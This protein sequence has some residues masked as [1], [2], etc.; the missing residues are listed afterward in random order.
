MRVELVI[1]GLLDAAA[2]VTALV[3]SRMYAINRPEGDALPAVV[4]NQIS[5]VP[6]PVLNQ[7]A[8]P[9]VMVARMQINCISDTPE[10]VKALLEQIRLALHLQSGT[11]N[12]VQTIS[13]LQATT[14]P[15]S[16]DRVTNTYAQPVDFMITYYR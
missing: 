1:K 13:I 3:G 2:G 15:D 4:W 8:G 5:D 14:G 6:H 11:I 16:Y 9:E 7:S 10:D 12:G